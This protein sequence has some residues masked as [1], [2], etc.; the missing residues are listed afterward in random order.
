MSGLGGGY[1]RQGRLHTLLGL[2]AGAV[3]LEGDQGG[4]AVARDPFGVAG[5]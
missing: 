2:V 5:I 3:D 1:R 4:M